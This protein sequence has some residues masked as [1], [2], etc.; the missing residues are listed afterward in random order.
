VRHGLHHVRPRD[1]H[2]RGAPHH[3][4]EVGDRGR[5][6]RAPSAGAE[7]RRDLRD[8]AREKRVANE[9]VGVAAKR[10]D[11]FLNARAARIV[12]P[13]DRR[14]IA[15]REIH[16]LADLLR[17]R[18]G[19][20]SA[21]DGEILGEDVDE[22]PRDAAVAGDHPVAVDGAAVA[23]SAVRARDGEAIEL[24]EAAFIE[25]HGEALARRELAFRVL[26]LEA[27]GTL[28]ARPPRGGA[29]AAPASL[30]SSWEAKA[31][32][33]QRASQPTA[34]ASSKVNEPS[35]SLSRARACCQASSRPTVGSYRLAVLSSMGR[36]ADVA[37]AVTSP[38]EVTV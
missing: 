28:P 16:D 6:H 4:N 30:A 11:A 20:R 2:V 32:R 17:V 37:D 13:N 12:E 24:G 26:R 18:L 29:R 9:D 5:V 19:E 33:P 14:T 25:E 36:L 3:V 7:D 31:T 23:V 15:R 34:A 35:R 1:E 8:D 38:L 27:F 21:E 10:D 22:T